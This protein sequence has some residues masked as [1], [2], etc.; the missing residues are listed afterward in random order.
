MS[1]ADEYAGF[2]DRRARR[3]RITAWVAIISLVLVG[4]GATVLALIFG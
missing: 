4:G 3:T 1:D 2:A